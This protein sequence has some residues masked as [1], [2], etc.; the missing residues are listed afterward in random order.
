M[1]SDNHWS[2]LLAH[3]TMKWRNIWRKLL[4]VAKSQAKSNSL[5][6]TAKCWDSS[7]TLKNFHL[8][9]T[10]ILLMIP[11]KSVKYTTLT[12]VVIL[13]LNCFKDRSCHLDQMLTNQALTL[14]VT[15]ILLVMR[16]TQ[17]NQSMCLAVYST[18]MVSMNTLQIS[19]HKNLVEHSSL[20]TLDTLK[21]LT[22]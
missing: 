13:S 5:T 7:A 9:F 16:S 4:V 10:T 15:T 3:A 18:L 17:T 19:T 20:V 21:H 11:L 22:Q 2:K 8:S 14:L 6:T 12:M 1:H